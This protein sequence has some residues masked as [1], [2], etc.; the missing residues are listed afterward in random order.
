MT[1]QEQ[2]ISIL[3]I[4]LGTMGTRFIAFIVFPSSKEP[5]RIIQF[6]AKLLP[7]AVMAM[8]VIYAYKDNIMNLSNLNMTIPTTIATLITI[9][10]HLWKRHLLLSISVGTIIYMLLHQLMQ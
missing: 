8:I 1:L 5:P 4:A 9:A 3:L 10:L 6:I 7:T 2:M